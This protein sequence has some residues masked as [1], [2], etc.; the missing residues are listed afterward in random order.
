[1]IVAIF[2]AASAAAGD[3][4]H[5]GG[6]LGGQKYSTSAHITPGNVHNL[7]K[8]WEFRTGDLT[9]RSASVL[10]QMKF[11]ATPVLHGDDLFVCSPFNEIFALDPGAGTVKWRF[12]PKIQIEAFRPSKRFNCRGV[13]VWNDS[14]AVADA[15]CRLRV[16]M[17]TNDGRVIAVDG[18][19]GVPCSDF[20]DKGQVKIDPGTALVWPG[21]F[22]ITSA[23]L[24][25]ADLVVV[26]SAIADNVRVDA[27]AGTVRAYDVRTG[28]L[29]WTW[30]PLPRTPEAAA[31]QGWTD[32]WR[33]TGHANV[34]APMSADA[35]RGL[36]FL[37][38]SSPSPD[39]FGGLRPGDNRHANSVVA[40]KAATGQVVWAYQIVHHDV[41]D[42]D[43][44]AQPTLTTLQLKGGARDVVI[45]GTKQGFVFV[46]DRETGQPVF[47]VEERPVPQGGAAG[48]RLAPS[49][50][51]PA[52]VPALTPQRLTPEMAWGLTPWDRAECETMIK[53]ARFDGLYTP[54]ME[55]GSIMY[56]ST[57]GGVNWGGVAFDP[58][59]QILFANTTRVPHLLVLAPNEGK[60]ASRARL[61]NGHVAAAQGA[62]FVLHRTLLRSSFDLP[63]SPPPWGV[64]SAIDL[65]GGKILWESTLG[66]TEETFRFGLA[67]PWG[68]VNFGGPVATGGGVVFTGAAADRYLRAFD[69]VTGKELWAGR[70]PSSAQATPMVYEWRGR[71]FVVIGAGGYPDFN[72]P[73]GDSFVA[74]A[75]PGPGERGPTLWSRTIDQ[76]GGRF[77]A[78]AILA[79][80]FLISVVLWWRWAKFR[81][82]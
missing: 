35:A 57:G 33:T 72:T 60:S 29:V 59:R 6:D 20:G 71:Q 51:F 49:Q 34:W 5:Y 70:L 10:Q 46:L 66:T 54:P 81:L 53:A 15:V 45:Q 40:L 3:W 52:H 17:G 82:W 38:T 27:P 7:V 12:D 47:P 31:A 58:R 76:P 9:R 14:R 16:F 61:A 78:M 26:G 73:A 56:P 13:A 1:L 50:P 68:T 63:C 39:F 65:K 8:V 74:F 22:Q 67:M 2:A 41:W 32:G 21:E 48:E 79:L 44:P 37:P 25:I 18:R 42:Y 75:L 28:A 24:I 30:D 77:W 11:Q 43:L 62:P 23:P 64:V 69:S 80:L 19:T 4:P 36:I 55:Q